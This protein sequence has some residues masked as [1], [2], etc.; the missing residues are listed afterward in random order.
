MTGQGDKNFERIKNAAKGDQVRGLKVERSNT[1]VIDGK[2]ITVA[3]YHFIITGQIHTQNQWL[4]AEWD[5]NGKHPQEQY[6]LM[7]IDKYVEPFK[8][9]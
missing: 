8:L 3:H 6:D 7:A 2:V 5:A 4:A 1:L 9:F